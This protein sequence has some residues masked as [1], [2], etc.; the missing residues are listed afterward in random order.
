MYD[1]R[2]W[3]GQARRAYRKLRADGRSALVL[4]DL[5][6][7]GKE[8]AAT[9]ARLEADYAADRRFSRGLFD[10]DF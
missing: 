10:S 9:L 4:A 6:T 2:D 1:L 7:L 8:K 5:A 3:L